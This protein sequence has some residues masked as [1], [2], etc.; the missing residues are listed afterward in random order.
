MTDTFKNMFNR[1][2][3]DEETSKQLEKYA[4]EYRDKSDDEIYQ[5]IERVQV[6]V[7]NDVKQRHIQN[8]ESLAKMEGLIGRDAVKTIDKL[9]GMIKIDE[10]ASSTRNR[11][12]G[13]YRARSIEA[14]FVTGASLL[15]WFLLVVILFR[16]C[17]PFF[18]GPFFY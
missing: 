11:Y 14:Q 1:I 12:R 6:D 2:F 16:C 3:Y 7:P 9:K 13:R 5:E 8:L 15:L 17:R 18:G 10:E 4:D